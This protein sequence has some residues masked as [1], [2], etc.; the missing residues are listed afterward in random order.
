M[1]FRSVMEK[2]A[3]DPDSSLLLG[4]GALA[5][6]LLGDNCTARTMAQE[7]LKEEPENEWA[8]ATLLAI[9]YRIDNVLAEYDF[10]G[11][12]GF[13]LDHLWIARFTRLGK[14]DEARKVVYC[15]SRFGSPLQKVKLSEDWL[16]SKEIEEYD[17]KQLELVL[18]S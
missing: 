13:R 16:V 10:F 12:E 7:V 15:L 2:L 6:F 5:F 11:P 9:H 18:E 4:M 1:L 8:L 14:T 3:W 17:E